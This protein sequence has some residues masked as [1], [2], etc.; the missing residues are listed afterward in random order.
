MESLN[1]SET[2]GY[3]LMPLSSIANVSADD[4]LKHDDA[5]CAAMNTYSLM[6][7]FAL[8]TLVPLA[9]KGKV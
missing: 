4:V 6:T 3:G 5:I 2:L 1:N 9:M 8:K 7:F